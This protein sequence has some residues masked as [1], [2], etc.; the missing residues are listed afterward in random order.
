M[1]QDRQSFSLFDFFFGF[2]QFNQ[3]GVAVNFR[4]LNGRSLRLVDL[5]VSVV[6]D[7]KFLV[8]GHHVG[9]ELIIGVVIFVLF[10]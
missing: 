6:D 1:H 8:E 7:S 4:L 9:F 3:R 2:S 5:V 10:V